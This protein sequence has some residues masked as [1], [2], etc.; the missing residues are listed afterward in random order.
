MN[1]R[2]DR[3]HI[4]S[5]KKYEANWPQ[6]EFI[7]PILRESIEKIIAEYCRN[8]MKVLDIGCG[9]QPFRPDFEKLNC[10]YFGLDIID[11]TVS[12]LDFLAS[13]EDPLSEEI[14][15]SGEYDFILCTEVLEHVADWNNAFFN[16]NKLIKKQGI[17]LITAPYFYQLHEEPFDYWRPSKYSIEYY[18]SR[19]QMELLHFYSAGSA[20]DVLGTLIANMNQINIK[21]NTVY[22]KIWRKIILLLKRRLFKLLKKRVLQENYPV[23]SLIYMS[24]IAVVTKY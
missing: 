22:F 21:K 15:T 5:R 4:V 2:I 13:I 12:G 16:L 24:N 10:E 19:H 9:A 18:S 23:D 8:G 11:Q 20:W 6:E 14:L 7:V 1:R 17:I 3:E